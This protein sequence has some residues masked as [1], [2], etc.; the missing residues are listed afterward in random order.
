MNIEL[1]SGSLCVIEIL[2]KSNA[3]ILLN[4]SPYLSLV[5]PRFYFGFCIPLAQLFCFLCILEGLVLLILTAAVCK[6]Y[7][8]GS[9]SP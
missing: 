4:I 5:S 2:C 7:L 6:S 1:S 8:C 9:C 3:I